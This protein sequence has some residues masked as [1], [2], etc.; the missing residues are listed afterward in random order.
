MKGY[1][2]P[3]EGV[4]TGKADGLS[5]CPLEFVAADGAREEFRPLR[6]LDGHSCVRCRPDLSNVIYRNQQFR[7][8]V[9]LCCFLS[10]FFSFLCYCL[11]WF[12]S[13]YK[14]SL[15]FFLNLIFF[16]FFTIENQQGRYNLNNYCYNIK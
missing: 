5:L 2:Y 12:F 1:S 8:S 15:V 9:S 14:E 7:F 4:S 11:K 10:F 13:R 6:S 3:A 16:F